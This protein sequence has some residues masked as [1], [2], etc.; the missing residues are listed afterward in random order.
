MRRLLLRTSIL[1]KVNGALADALTGGSDGERIL[2][3][4][5]DVNAFVV[6]LDTGR[7]WFRYHQLFA[8]LLRLELRRTD[9]KAVE[10]L[11]R[12]A[13][14]WHAE[15][16]NMLE[17]IR[18]AQAADDWGRAAR[19][20]A[21][22]WV[23][24]WLNGQ[25]ATIQPLLKAFPARV[26]AEPELAPVLA[27]E[28]LELGTLDEAAAYVAFGERQA[29]SV[30]VDRRSR[31]EVA[32]GIVRLWLARRLGDVGSALD[33]VHALRQLTSAELRPRPGWATRSGRWR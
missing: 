1:E 15:H 18:H 11:H 26:A 32:L 8:D 9:P 6:S 33:E 22:H 28:Q 7:T 23:G 29:A 25:M 19:L 4:L 10:G 17:A 24:L 5:E 13:A 21:D 14:G 12:A 3:D 31:F 30:P 27:A 2:Q 20:L 16:G